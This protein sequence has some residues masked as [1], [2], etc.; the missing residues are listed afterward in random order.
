MKYIYTPGPV[1]MSDEILALGGEQAPYFRNS[2]FS[3]II[4]ESE[5]ILLDIANAPKDSRVV[6][7]TASGTG[8][9][10]AAVTNLLSK[11]DNA[12]VVNGGGFGQR[13]VDICT[14]FSIPNKVI[15]PQGN[16]ETI[17]VDS[18]KRYTHFI[19]NAHETSIGI[20]YNLKSIGAFCKDNNLLN[21]VDAISLFLTDEVDMQKHSIDALIISSQKAFALPPGISMIILSPDAIV[22]L[23]DIPS[24]YFN[25]KDYL[26]DGERGQ[27]PFTPAVTILLQLHHRLK[28]IYRKGLNKELE[29]AAYIA[30]YFREKIKDLPLVAYT[31]F[32]PNAMT[33]LT[34]TDGRSAREIVSDLDEKYNVVVCPNGG[35]LKD[36]IF[37]VSHM[38]A[39]TIEYT[40][41][42]IDSL[43]KYYG[44]KK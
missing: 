9:M 30:H 20:Y 44:V 35:E 43:F 27:T 18:A 42:L 26:R 2:E 33:T 24:L 4:L 37:R 39:M 14:R 1:K 21:I 25:F 17:N 13:F 19:V 31:S 5:K 38:G 23:K 3:N 8:A 7:L 12:L 6:F 41:I 16:L 29:N 32:M 22:S 15:I 28:E 40:D 34:P 11:S 36:K 10:E